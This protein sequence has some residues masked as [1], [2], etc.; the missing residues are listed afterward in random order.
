MA[1]EMEQTDVVVV[2][3]D[4]AYSMAKVCCVV[5]RK[6]QCVACLMNATEPMMAE[7]MLGQMEHGEPPADAEDTKTMLRDWVNHCKEAMEEALQKPCTKDE[8]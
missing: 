3:E 1:I 7:W 2:M 8:S 4:L 6:P 5:Y